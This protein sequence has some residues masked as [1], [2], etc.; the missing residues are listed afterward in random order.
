MLT[1]NQYSN[2]DHM[3]LQECLLLDEGVIKDLFPG[4]WSF[5]S[6]LSHRREYMLAVTEWIQN[7]DTYNK[8]NQAALEKVARIFRSVD[9]NTLKDLINT[10]VKSKKLSDKYMVT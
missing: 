9:R 4:I 10:M 3:Q 8:K 5:F 2:R 1:F 6:H 7:V